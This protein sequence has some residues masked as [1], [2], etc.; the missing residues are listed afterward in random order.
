MIRRE[1]KREVGDVDWKGGRVAGRWEAEQ[2][3]GDEA[4]GDGW[5]MGAGWRWSADG[6]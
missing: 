6:V 3:V 1:E 5:E 4:G 2:G